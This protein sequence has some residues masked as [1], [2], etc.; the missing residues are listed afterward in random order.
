[1]IGAQES[2]AE[3]AGGEQQ[4]ISYGSAPE[5]RVPKNIF[6]PSLSLD[7]VDEEEIARQLTIIQYQLYAAIN[8][9]CLFFL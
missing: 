1:M 4:P 7:D 8:V 6:S 9:L 3:V 5:P 2:G